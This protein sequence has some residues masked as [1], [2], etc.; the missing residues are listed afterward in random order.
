MKKKL[1]LGIIP[2]FAFISAN[3]QKL[4][5]EMQINAFQEIFNSSNLSI[6]N[7]NPQKT[8]I[9]GIG[10]GVNVGLISYSLDTLNPEKSIA[11]A[12]I[13][14]NINRTLV[15]NDETVNLMTLGGYWRYG[16]K[17]NDFCKIDFGL[18]IAWARYN[19][20][21]SVSDKDYSYTKNGTK[22]AFGTTFFF[23]PFKSFQDCEIGLGL[24]YN[25]YMFWYN[26]SK[27]D[28]I[29]SQ[30]SKHSELNSLT[31][32]ISLKCTLPLID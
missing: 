28:D 22:V 29:V 2:L 17:L 18:E 13:T 23:T 32:F 6:L 14:F 16:T 1:I 8:Y 9:S 19:N 26:D 7:N 27:I 12:G 30:L 5:F 10:Y 3:A 31:P 25:A 24:K 11:S 4:G 20:E 21:F 15:S